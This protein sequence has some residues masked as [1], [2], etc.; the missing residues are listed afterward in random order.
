MEKLV[1]DIKKPSSRMKWWRKYLLNKYGIA[2]V[3]F[4]VWM[5]FFDSNSFLVINELDGEINRYE[6][7]LDFYKKEYEKNDAFYK[8]L[9]NNKSEREKFARENYF[10]K[11]SNEEIFILV[12]D[13]ANS[14]K[15]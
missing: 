12:V 15:K 14:V 9:M 5:T 8:K 7:Q 11:K 4:L 10:M 1:K 3:V 13:S 2:I 6:K